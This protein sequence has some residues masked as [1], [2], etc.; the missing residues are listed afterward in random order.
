MPQS[1]PDSGQLPLLSET[2]T[3]SGFSQSIGQECRSSGMSA[4]ST[5]AGT[6]QQSFLAGSHA[7]RSL[8]LG[9]DWVRTI[10]V[11]S[12]LNICGLSKSVGQLGLLEKML[13]ASSTWRST[14]C[15]PIWRASAT[16]RGR[17]IFQLAPLGLTTSAGEYL[18][19][20]TMGASEG[21]GAASNRYIGS[22][23]F[24]GAKMAEGLRTSR[25]DPI[26]LAPTFAE[27]VM[28]FPDGWTALEHSE[29]P[30]SPNKP[31]RSSRQSRKSR[32]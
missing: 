30:S 5:Q 11:R 6:G 10:T 3:A 12:G 9:K 15:L 32:A 21:L 4:H 27:Q 18:L 17:L 28:G 20:P 2:P 19:L 14:T 25:L 26:Y 29:T 7:S 8:S 13:L 23:H 22:P 31:I 24:R 1:G 16:P